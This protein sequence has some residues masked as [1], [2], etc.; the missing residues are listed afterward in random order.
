MRLSFVAP[1]TNGVTT[2]F[3]PFN[4]KFT[5]PIFGEE[6]RIFG[7]QNLRI[8]LRFNASDMRPHVA[9]AYTK[10]FQPMGDTEAANIPELLEDFLP[11]GTSYFGSESLQLSLTCRSGF[12]EEQ[13]LGSSHQD[14]A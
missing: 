12:P 11:P 3:S 1:T 2:L 8:D 10:K 6:Q 14:G 7:Y 13:R 5:Y 4:P 9:I